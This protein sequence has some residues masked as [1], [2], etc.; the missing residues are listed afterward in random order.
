MPETV[1]KPHAE[2]H[3]LLSHQGYLI[4]LTTKRKKY[5]YEQESCWTWSSS[6]DR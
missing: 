6:T 3:S 5:Q 2:K 1:K 4:I